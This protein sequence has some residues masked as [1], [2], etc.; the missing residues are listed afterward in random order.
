VDGIGVENTNAEFNPSGSS[1]HGTKHDG[2]AAQKEIIA[3]PELIKA[4]GF[5]R[6]RQ[7]DNVG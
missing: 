7:G 2:R 6:L 4:R 5:C 3:D 1:A